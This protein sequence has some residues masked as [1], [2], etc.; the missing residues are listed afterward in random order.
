M[1]TNDSPRQLEM[2]FSGTDGNVFKDRL[3]HADFSALLEIK[4]PGSDSDLAAVVSKY[5]ELEQL[6]SSC[7]D[8]PC[9]LAFTDDSVEFPSLRMS[10]FAAALCKSGRDR[11]LLYL[12]GRDRTEDDIRYELGLIRNEGFR[13]IAAVSGMTPASMKSAE[14]HSW[15]ESVGILRINASLRE[16]LY[17]GCVANPFKYTKTDSMTQ[18]FKLT[19][20]IREG[21][22]FAVVQ[23][24]WDMAKLLELRWSMFR[25]G[26]NIP[27]IA[28][29]LFLSPEKAED[30]CAGKMQG[31]NL[32]DDFRQ[33]IRKEMSHSM[34]QFEAA[35]L[36]RFQI[37]AAG[38]KF[39]GYS[40]I[41]IAGIDRPE[42][43]ELLLNR[44]RDAMQEFPSSDD[45]R[46]AYADY[47]ARIDLAPSPCRYY[48]FENPFAEGVT[49]ENAKLTTEPLP[50]C[51]FSDRLKY[52]LARML[53]SHA[54]RM[55][56]SD[57][58]LTKKLLASCRRNC[59]RCTL[60]ENL[61]VCPGRCPKFMQNGP[62][63]ETDPSGNCPLTGTE[64][65]YAEKLRRA[66]CFNEY[67]VLEEKVIE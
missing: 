43:A 27:L 33:V 31:I 7:A 15:F 10:D 21:A 62:C 51:S 35:Q 40:G 24:G 54:G 1:K 5:A 9:G 36:R 20:K 3:D 25:R 47:Y 29:I 66:V 52:R 64:C 49:Y 34:N 37:H 30:I 61:F 45:W 13:N 56:V 41:Q 17:A 26:Q 46:A 50:E 55:P 57:R 32:S 67:A 60:S 16:P 19:K 14:D 58:L 23:A 65:I 53:L 11:H 39:L 6:A 38:A 18:T 2:N 28:R 12:N 8:F 48:M 4:V 63:G 59:S 22:S 44:L 42:T